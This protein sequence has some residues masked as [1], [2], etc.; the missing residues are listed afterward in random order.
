MFLSMDAHVVMELMQATAAAVASARLMSLKPGNQ[1]PAILAFLMFLAGTDLGLGLMDESSALYFWSYFAVEPLKCV[2]DFLAVRELF[3][4][5][6]R[7][8]L[9]L[10]SVSRWVMYGVTALSLIVSLLVTG[11]FWRGAAAGR[12]HSHLF[13]L[14]VSVR[15]VML[16]LAAAIVANLLFLSKYPLRL[17]KNTLVCSMFFSAMFL[18]QS[19][20]LFADSLAP[21]L[22]DRYIDSSEEVFIIAC[23][24]AWTVM[25]KPETA[26]K[27]A[28]IRFMTPDEN[29]LLDQL[30]ALNQMMTRSARR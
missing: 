4:L 28:V 29:H 26:A 5:T 19:F 9:G 7:A 21:R 6:F 25:L 15:T 22:Y 8:Y 12:E 18:S 24:A 2:F 1:F 14:E 11:F 23:L 10:K 16:A 13:Y 30:N 27:P 17:N 3:A 20:C